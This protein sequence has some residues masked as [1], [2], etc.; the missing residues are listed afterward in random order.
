[1][2][3]T[4]R[5]TYRDWKDNGPTYSEKIDGPL[6]DLSVRTISGYFGVPEKGAVHS[7]TH[8]VTEGMAV[9]AESKIHRPADGGPW[10][11]YDFTLTVFTAPANVTVALPGFSQ[12]ELTSAL[13]DLRGEI[14]EEMLLPNFILELPEALELHKQLIGAFSGALS[15]TGAARSYARQRGVDAANTHLL[16]QFGL[17]PLAS[18]LTTLWQ[19][20]SRIRKRLDYFRHV[21]GGDWTSWRKSIR[22]PKTATVSDWYVSYADKQ[23]LLVDDVMTDASMFARIKRCRQIPVSDSLL[24]GLDA[25]GF[26]KVGDVIWEAIPFSFVADWFYPCGQILSS[27]N[28]TAF[29]SCLLNQMVGYQHSTWC[30]FRVLGCPSVMGYTGL[31]NNNVS[32][33][34]AG[35]ARRY[36]R[37][38]GYPS[39]F[40]E[41]NFGVRQSLLSG[42]LAL[43]HLG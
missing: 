38:P 12:S 6:R 4:W 2:R 41:S 5:S 1:M 7:V 33:L 30:Q 18:D 17:K 22:T 34:F 19:L 25:S 16:Y 15:W 37:V 32:T 23:S 40:T 3:P 27:L 20:G 9:R 36:E 14:P 13:Q 21:S 42:S 43:Q 28:M 8:S 35:T 11:G 29:E 26:S 10:S 31:V 39:T 24:A